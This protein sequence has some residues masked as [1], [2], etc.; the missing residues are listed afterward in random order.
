MLPVAFQVPVAGLYSSALARKLPPT[1]SATRTVPLDRRMAF[2]EWRAVAMEPVTRKVKGPA[3]M[4]APAIVAARS[5][6]SAPRAVDIVTALLTDC[7]PAV[8]L[9]VYPRD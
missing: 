8:E 6:T 2:G 7:A 4:A 1:P 3:A 9:I 5:T